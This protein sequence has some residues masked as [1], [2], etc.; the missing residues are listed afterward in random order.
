MGG[1]FERVC[2]EGL[3]ILFEIIYQLPVRTEE[4]RNTLE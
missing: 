4:N 3:L 1:E 2:N